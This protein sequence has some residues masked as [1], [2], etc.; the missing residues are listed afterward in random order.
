MEAPQ[1][2][3]VVFAYDTPEQRRVAMEF[4]QPLFLRGE[5]LRVV[6][7][8]VDNELTR[9]NLIRE[10][11]ERIDDHYDLRETIQAIIE[12]PDLSKWSWDD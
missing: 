5:G 1:T 6:G 10:A 7:L 9:L 3:T 2:D 11:L 4:V 12:C 8:S